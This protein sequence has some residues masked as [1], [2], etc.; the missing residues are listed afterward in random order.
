MELSQ[1]QTFGAAEA[2]NDD[3]LL[4][5]F[6]DHEAYLKARA[7]EKFLIVGRKGSGKT[8]IFKKLVSEQAWNQFCHG[9]SFSDYP[10]FHH[11]KQRK[12]G[13]P[14]S[15]CFR[16]SWEYVILVSVAKILINDD[17]QPWSDESLEAMSR[18]ETFICDTYGSKSPELNRIFSPET[19]LKLKPSLT[20]G[21]GPLKGTLSAERV[22]IDHLPTIIYEVNDALMDTVVRC[23]NPEHNYYVCFDELDRGFVA[24]DMTYRNRLSGL[25]IAARDFNRRVRQSGKNMTAIVFL[26]DDILRYLEFE[27]KNKIVEDFSSVIEWDKSSV[28][29]SLKGVMD[30]RLS[31]VLSIDEEGAWPTV[32]NEEQ[33]MPGRQNKYQYMLDRTFK[34]PRDIIKYCNEVLRSYKQSG[35]NSNKFEN[36]DIASAREEYSRYARRELIDEM[37]QHFP[38]H[39]RAFDTLRVIGN[40]GFTIAKFNE[41][42][43][44]ISKVRG[45]T[46]P[47]GEMLRQ[48]YVFSVVGYLKVGGSGGGSEWVWK[49]EDTEAAYD[50]RATIFRVHPSLKEVLGLKQGRASVEGEIVE[51][52]PVPEDL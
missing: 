30:K 44:S 8:A 40:I 22:E 35:R 48:L 13:V 23:L 46:L 19:T 17:A 9:H 14:D 4:D 5:C 20:A 28:P 41:A 39:E 32:F 24:D 16:Y 2:D 51:A 50:D 38:G 27:D 26:R 42:H 34:R 18:L 7:H 11:D 21:W 3:L 12:T 6:E 25:L 45:E 36:I 43:A 1:V 31:K 15:E 10:W 47:S 49:Y 33:Q 29:N 52:P 37:Q